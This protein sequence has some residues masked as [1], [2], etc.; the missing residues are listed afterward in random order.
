MS[1]SNINRCESCGAWNYF[2][3]YY[4]LTGLAFICQ[5]C[6]KVRKDK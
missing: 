5:R 4:R 3:E 2:P 6:V 1:E